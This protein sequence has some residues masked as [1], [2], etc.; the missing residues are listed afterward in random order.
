MG[1]ANAGRG[2]GWYCEAGAG[3][4]E[5]REEADEDEEEAAADEDWADSEGS[6]SEGRAEM[7]AGRPAMTY[8]GRLK[9][10]AVP[11]AVA[12]SRGRCGHSRG[13]SDTG[14]GGE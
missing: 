14:E 10:P 6:A 11:S 5:A 3:A 2:G 12:S 13:H 8:D 9:P 7:T 1:G 4:R